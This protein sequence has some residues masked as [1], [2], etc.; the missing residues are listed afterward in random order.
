MESSRTGSRIRCIHVNSN[1][2]IPAAVLLLLVVGCA[3]VPSLKSDS[4]IL[5]GRTDVVAERETEP[6]SVTNVSYQETSEEAPES[7]NAT[8]APIATIKAV[9]SL[10]ILELDA[11]NLNPRL[12]SLAQQAQ[13]AQ[14]KARYVDK[15]PDPK[16]GANVFTHPIET[17]A[18]SQRANM[19]LVQLLP[20]L[21]RLNAQEQQACFE[22]MALQQVYHAERLKVVGDVRALWFR[23]YVLSKQIE[24]I[25]ANQRLL[26]SLTDIA[27]AAIATGKAGSGDVLLG[28]VEYSKLEEQLLILRQQVESTQAEI[29]RLVGRSAATQIDGPQSIDVNL[30]DW[31]HQMLTQRAIDN[32]PAIAAAQ[33]QTQAT[34]WGLEVAR[35]QRRPDLALNANWYEIDGNRPPTGIVDVGQDAW[36]LGAQVSIPLWADKYDAMEQEARWKH[37]ASHASVDD[38]VQRFDALLRDLWEQAKTTS[39]TAELYKSTILPQAKQTLAADQQA[40]VNGSVEFDRVMRD[41]RTVLTLELGYHKAIGQLATALARIEQAVG[42]KL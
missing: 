8:A 33:I 5:P 10:R 1:A 31:S 2:C 28:T 20:S 24:T 16:L 36:S 40:F 27:N 25:T 9:D 39:E 4:R 26:K 6:D 11:L 34:R 14:A 22:A 38:T 15:L 7:A 12:R 23:L 17:A 32:Q 30:P 3:T 35:L 37:A 29:N 13:A 18:G 21:K 19:S 41:F 42:T